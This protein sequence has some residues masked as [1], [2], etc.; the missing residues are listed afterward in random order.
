[1]ILS[2][3]FLPPDRP[4][5]AEHDVRY[6]A[7]TGRWWK[8]TSP[9]FAGLTVDWDGAEDARLRLALPLEY[10]SRLILQ[11]R[12]FSDDIRFEGLW[13][14]VGGGGWRIVTSQPDVAG[15]PANLEQIDRSL[16]QIGF[17]PLPIAGVGRSGALAF[18]LAEVALWDAHPAN[19]FIAANDLVVPI[20]LILTEHPLP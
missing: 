13:M 3:G 2:A 8:Y 6:D 4:G 16:R 1:M 10:F 12:I 14:D 18:R 19:F 17:F 9:G 20:D 15:E 5:G 7:V 11:N